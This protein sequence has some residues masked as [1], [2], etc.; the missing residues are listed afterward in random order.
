[1]GKKNSKYVFGLL[2]YREIMGKKKKVAETDSVSLLPD[3][4][5][6]HVTVSRVNVRSS[7]G[8]LLH[9]GIS[10]NMLNI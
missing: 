2:F 10:D 1:M 3:W 5:S 6:F 4:V 8:F 7:S 9:N